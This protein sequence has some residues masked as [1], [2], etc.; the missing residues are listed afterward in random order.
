MTPNK[1]VGRFAGAYEWRR[2]ERAQ[3]LGLL[4]AVV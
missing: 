4:V 3:G 2:Q 1:R